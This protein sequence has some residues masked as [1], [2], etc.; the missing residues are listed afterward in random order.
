[1]GCSMWD[2]LW[3][4]LYVGCSKHPGLAANQSTCTK[5]PQAQAE[6][7]L[8]CG[9]RAIKLLLGGQPAPSTHV[10]LFVVTQPHKAAVNL[11]LLAQGNLLSAGWLRV[12]GAV[13]CS[14]ANT[15]SPTTC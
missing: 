13:G 4:M 3:A 12:K 5:W 15:A 9:Q 6:R 8:S 14:L 7:A 11:D 2:A 1:M 10:G